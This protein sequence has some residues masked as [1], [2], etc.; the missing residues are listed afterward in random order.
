MGNKV[1]ERTLWYVKKPIPIEAIQWNGNNFQEIQDFMREHH[2]I[3]TAYNE[4]IIPTLEGEM[5]APVE[6]WI[7][8]GPMGE[9]YPCRRDVF[10]ETYEPVKE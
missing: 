5:K 10:E 1:V 9:Y 8:R 7:I 6:S 2:V 3:K 4:L